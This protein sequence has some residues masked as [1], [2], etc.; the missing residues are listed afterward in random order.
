MKFPRHLV[1]AAA[2]LA[3]APLPPAAVADAID[4]YRPSVLK[5][6]ERALQR[7]HPGLTLEM[8]DGRLQGLRPGNQRAEGY[9]LTCRAQFERGDYVDA[10][11]Y[12]DLAVSEGGSAA[13]RHLN[14]RGVMR[15]MQ[16]RNAE[17]LADF[18][19]AQRLAPAERDVSHN[20]AVARK[21]LANEPLEVSVAA[22][23]E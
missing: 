11:R 17:A 13:W 20:L 23:P 4:H 9:A 5:I 18:R 19:A 14:N 12:C 6:A 16:G 7:G 1:S 3:L 10:E 22:A 2:L 15:L 8:L 21:K